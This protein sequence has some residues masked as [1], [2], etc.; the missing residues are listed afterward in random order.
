MRR[1]RVLANALLICVLIAVH[2]ETSF[3]LE[4]SLIRLLDTVHNVAANDIRARRDVAD[5]TLLIMSPPILELFA[6]C[7][8]IQP[9]RDISSLVSCELLPSVLSVDGG[10]DLWLYGRKRSS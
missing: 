8:R 1:S 2:N 3:E 9:V 5:V 10:K 4:A 7:L 6:E